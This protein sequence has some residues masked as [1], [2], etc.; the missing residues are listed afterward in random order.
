MLTFFTVLFQPNEMGSGGWIRSHFVQLASLSFA[1]TTNL[2]S[3]YVIVTHESSNQLHQLPIEMHQLEVVKIPDVEVRHKELRANW[4]LLMDH[5][6]IAF[7]KRL[8]SGSPCVYVE[9][10]QLFMPGAGL[11]F[12]AVFAKEIFDIAFTYR[13]KRTH[14]GSTNTGVVLFRTS[15]PVIHWLEAAAAQLLA[16]TGNLSKGGENQLVIDRY[17]PHLAWGKRFF[18]RD[19]WFLSLPFPGPLNDVTMGCC[20]LKNTSFVAHLKSTRKEWALSVCC[21]DRVQ[22]RINA[23]LA[24]CTCAKQDKSLS[25]RCWPSEGTWTSAASDWCGGNQSLQQM[26]SDA[27]SS[28]THH[29]QG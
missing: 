26:A 16:L 7:L 1:S 8:P 2:H 13:S 28:Q 3:R 24:D 20:A 17:L 21:R 19:L 11:A 14:R 29:G 12:E 5:L 10:D 4:V 27:A 18:F 6:K 22:P 9:L 25:A 23:W 15:A